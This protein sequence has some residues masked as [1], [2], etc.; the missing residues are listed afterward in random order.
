MLANAT[1]ANLMPLHVNKSGI[2]Y[3]CNN[4]LGYHL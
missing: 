1:E 4:I 2:I 3:V